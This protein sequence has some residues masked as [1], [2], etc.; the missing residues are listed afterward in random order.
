MNR[1]DF[2]R[3]G[4]LCLGLAAVPSGLLSWLKSK[5]KSDTSE[6]TYP[7][8]SSN[9]DTT[10]TELTMEKMQKLFD[11]C[12]A[13]IGKPGK[14]YMTIPSSYEEYKWLKR[15]GYPDEYIIWG[16]KRDK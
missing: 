3:L 8:W 11:L 12:K 5:V 7:L 14:L 6:A 9:I 10:P 1:R 4:F 16:G 13:D 15:R 2:V